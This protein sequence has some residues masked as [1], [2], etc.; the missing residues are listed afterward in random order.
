M[1]AASLIRHQLFRLGLLRSQPRTA[2]WLFEN[3]PCC[4]FP[5]SIHS[6]LGDLHY[7]HQLTQDTEPPLAGLQSAKLSP[8]ALVFHLCAVLQAVPCEAFCE[9]LSAANPD[10]ASLLQ[11]LLPWYDTLGTPTVTISSSYSPS[12]ESLTLTIKQ[13]NDTAKEVK[14]AQHQPVLIPVKV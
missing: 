7:Q 1:Q 12:N 6:S 10:H 8:V 4:H 5:G 2:A 13:R 9:A 11:G 3:L 14:K